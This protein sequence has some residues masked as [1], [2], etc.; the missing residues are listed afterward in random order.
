MGINVGDEDGASAEAASGPTVGRI[1]RRS[2]IAA[3]VTAGGA[4][5]LGIRQRGSAVFA[6]TATRAGQ[7]PGTPDATT[8]ADR[9]EGLTIVREQDPVYAGSPQPS[10][11][12]RLMRSPAVRDD[13]SPVSF[14]QDFQITVSYLDPLLRPDPLTM[15]PGP[16]LAERWRWSEDGRTIT[17]TLRDDVRWHDG[18]PFTSEDVGFSFLAYRDDVDS[19]VGAVFSVM[20]D[21]R[22]VDDRTVAVTL[23]EVDGS[24]LFNASTQ[25][26]F[27]AAQYGRY[28]TSKPPGAQ[29]L[30]GFDWSEEMPIGTGPWRVIDWDNS[31]VSFDRFERSW[32]VTPAFER[33]TVGWEDDEERRVEAWRRG[34]VDLLWPVSPEVVEEVQGE[35]GTLVVGDGATVMFAAFNFFNPLRPEPGIFADVRVRRALSLAI[36]RSQYAEKVFETFIRQRAAGTLAQP[37]ANAPEVTNPLQ[38]LDGAA[39]LLAEAG[40]FDFDGDGVLDDGFGQRFSITVIVQESGRDDVRAILRSVR[41]DLIKVGV[42][43]RIETLS[44][45]AFRGR[46]LESRDYD[47]IALAYALAPGFTDFDLY[48]S[49]WDVR[50]NPRGFNPGGYANAEADAAIADA[51]GTVDPT[52]QRDALDRL[53]VAVD[54]DLFGLWFG[55][56]RDLVLVGAE[57]RGFRPNKLWATADTALLW[58]T[59]PRSD[60]SPVGSPASAVSTPIATPTDN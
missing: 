12:L 2:A 24:W 40:W 23:S 55:F 34:E 9:P 42:E 26:V 16:W 7:T 10:G 38:D 8:R 46:W 37:W 60:A 21:V 28:W 31:G 22:A 25:P 4:L 43:M 17:Y 57:L 14:R 56:P 11:L 18:S 27:Q 19:G 36:D 41:R 44:E 45:A 1:D 29:T 58:P 59:D 13:F 50:V 52:A 54:E 49:A 15:M 35:P 53:Q 47:L 3:V 33:M 20:E 5:V 6:A 48:G 30:T 39:A 32:A 51:L